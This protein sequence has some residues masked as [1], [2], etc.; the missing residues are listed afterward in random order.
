MIVI[1]IIVYMVHITIFDESSPLDITKIYN[2]KKVSTITCG[3]KYL[4][5]HYYIYNHFKDV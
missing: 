5:S 4:S 1:L 2:F 3:K